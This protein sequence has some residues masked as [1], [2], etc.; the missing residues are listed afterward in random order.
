[1]TY[2]KWEKI[3]DRISNNFKI[4]EHSDGLVER[5]GG[6]EEEYVVF[7]GP[8]GPIK[9]EYLAKPVLLDKKVTYSNRIGSGAKVDYIY[10]R[11]QKNSVLKAYKWD[12][13]R[14][15]WQEIDADNFSS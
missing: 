15:G 9:L 2:D 6:I 11:D 3:I 12:D 1:M 14:D 8:A 7:E 5:E 10:S 4:L 13:R